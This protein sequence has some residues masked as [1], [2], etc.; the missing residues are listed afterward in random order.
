MTHDLTFAAFDV[1]TANQRR[2]SICAIG[3]SMV[4]NG[5]R[6]HS[7]S[8]LCRP[9]TGIDTFAPM[10][11]RIHKITPQQVANKPRFHEVWP[12]VLGLIGNVP[13]IAHNAEFDISAVRQACEQSR[14]PVP[15]WTY[16]CT[17]EYAQS[18]LSL[19]NNK[20]PTVAAALGV[21]LLQHHDATC[22]A[23]AAADI[24]IRLAERTG[25]TDLP[26]LA[27]VS[28]C[29]LRRTIGWSGR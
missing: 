3:I 27:R 20:L 11:I 9:P 23:D 8:W 7:R 4:V 1:E 19:H 21:K 16:G 29:R 14:L 6:T 15:M 13:V 18:L 2:G 22:D 5:I 26:G 25:T 12:E 17:K 10:N 24:V 28:G